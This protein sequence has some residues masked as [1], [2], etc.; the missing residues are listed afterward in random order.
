M[1]WLTENQGFTG[2]RG[3]GAPNLQEGTRLDVLGELRLHRSVVLTSALALIDNLGTSRVV[4]G[5]MEVR[6]SF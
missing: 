1:S 4:E 2:I 6:G 5:R 3:P